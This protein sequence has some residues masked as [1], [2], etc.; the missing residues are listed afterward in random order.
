MYDTVSRTFTPGQ[1]VIESS[2]GLV[3]TVVSIDAEV[4]SYGG[5]IYN[6]EGLTHRQYA[7][8]A[9]IPADGPRIRCGCCGQLHGSV[10][11]VSWCYEVE[12]EARWEQ[13]AGL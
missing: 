8:H 5:P 13:A 12:A 2:T 9:I 7:D 10:G 1:Q 4:N 6:V 3:G 11:E